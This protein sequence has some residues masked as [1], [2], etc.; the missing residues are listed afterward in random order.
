MM[1][2]SYLKGWWLIKASYSMEC[3]I[4]DF[5]GCEDSSPRLDLNT[6]GI[7]ATNFTKHH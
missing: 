6:S 2:I 3:E 4:R 7:F 1:L 5:H